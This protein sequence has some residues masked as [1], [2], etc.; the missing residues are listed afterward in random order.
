M[1]LHAHI[2]EHFQ[3]ISAVHSVFSSCAAL[4]NANTAPWIPKYELYSHPRSAAEHH[5]TFNSSSL[6]LVT[7][8]S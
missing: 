5:L 8:T 4:R 2:S 1:A 6:G 3:S 7:V